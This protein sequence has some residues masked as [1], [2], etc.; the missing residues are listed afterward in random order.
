MELVECPTRQLKLTEAGCA[1][2]WKSTRIRPPQAWEGRQACRGCALGAMRAGVAPEKA[3]TPPMRVARI[4][5]RCHK[6]AERVIQNRL[7]ISCYNREGEARRGRDRNG[8]R[9]VLA[10]QLYTDS[11][12][13]H[14]SS[15]SYTVTST[16]LNR[17]ELM[18][19][20]LHT[21]TENLWF[22]ARR[23][24]NIPVPGLQLSLP[25]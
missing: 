15:R 24:L 7:C 21:A 17:S 1:A 22:T 18:L 23:R 12:D 14:N 8:H 3:A 4:C 25:L 20:A 11:I 6:Q 9:P 2:L 16:V 13:V 19:Q 5:V 10:D